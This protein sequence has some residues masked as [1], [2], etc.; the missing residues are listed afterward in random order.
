MADE[1]T[2]VPARGCSP[3]RLEAPG[4]LTARQSAGRT[5]GVAVVPVEVRRGVGFD[6]AAILL[7]RADA[8]YVWTRP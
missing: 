8:L 5:L 2:S 1:L 7:A 3:P 4:A 6:S